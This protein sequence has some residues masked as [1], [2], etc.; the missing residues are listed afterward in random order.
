[1]T[2]NKTPYARLE[3][4][5]AVRFIERAPDTVYVRLVDV[6]KYFAIGPADL[7]VELQA[8]RLVAEGTPSGAG[9]TDIVIRVDK[10]LSWLNS[11]SPIANRA[12]GHMLRPWWRKA[13]D[14]GA[15]LIMGLSA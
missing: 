7:L 13:I 2:A 14:A 8:G 5:V 9:Y 12:R 15:A 3:P 11:G 1:M 6:P 10:F 4:E